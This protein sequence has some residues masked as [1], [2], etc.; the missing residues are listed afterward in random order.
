MSATWA[1]WHVGFALGMLTIRAFYLLKRT[2][3]AERHVEPLRSR[4]FGFALMANVAASN[5]AFALLCPSP[6]AVCNAAPP[7]PDWLRAV[8]ACLSAAGLVLFARSH[9]A[10][11]ASWSG[12]VTL[13]SA[14]RLVT[15][16]PYRI[17]RHPMYAAAWLYA[18]GASLLSAN[19]VVA[20]SFVM[21]AFYASRRMALEEALMVATFGGAYVEYMKGTRR[22]VPWVY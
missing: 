7:C 8:G 17:V 1:E 13:R 4:L 20:L 6:H 12:R 3:T 9:A 22:L 19:A 21:L 15:D 2:S 5:A 18:I 11:G 10:L 16:G 14:H